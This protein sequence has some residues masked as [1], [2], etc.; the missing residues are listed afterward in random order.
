MT[1]N[2]DALSIIRQAIWAPQDERFLAAAID[3]LMGLMQL[4]PSISSALGLDRVEVKAV[5]EYLKSN[6]KSPQFMALSAS[7]YKAHD[8]KHG[9]VEHPLKGLLTACPTFSIAIT[10]KS[11]S[12]TDFSAYELL[13]SQ[14]LERCISRNLQVAHSDFLQSIASIELIESGVLSRDAGHYEPYSTRLQAV[15][16]GLRRLVKVPIHDDFQSAIE[17][18]SYDDWFRSTKPLDRQEVAGLK[19]IA[20]FILHPDRSRKATKGKR[21]GRRQKTHQ[22]QSVPGPG[23][24]LESSIIVQSEPIFDEQI[25]IREIPISRELQYKARVA[26][27]SPIELLDAKNGWDTG[28]ELHIYHSA[29]SARLAGGYQNQHKRNAAELLPWHLS[30]VPRQVQLLIINY[31]DEHKQSSAQSSV[32]A[33]LLLSIAS[34]RYLPQALHGL[35]VRRDASIPLEQYFDASTLIVFDQVEGAIALTVNAAPLVNKVV[36]ATARQTRSYVYVPDYFGI[37]HAFDEFFNDPSSRAYNLSRQSVSYHLNTSQRYLDDIKFRF[38]VSESQLWQMLPRMM[39][40]DAGMFSAMVLLT[41]WRTLNATVD[42]HYFAPQAEYVVSRY[43]SAMSRLLSDDHGKFVKLEAALPV[44]NHYVGAINCPSASDIKRLISG[45]SGLLKRPNL[46]SADR[47]NYLTLYTLLLCTA[48]FGL[49]HSL[50]PSFEISKYGS[51]S[52]MTYVEKGS[53]RCFVVPKLVADQIYVQ[54]ECARIRLLD[55]SIRR[56]NASPQGSFF[57]IDSHNL[58]TKIQPNK[59]SELLGTIKIKF[60]YPLNSLRRMMF[61][62]AFEYGVRGPITDF[63]GGHGVDGRK[64]FAPMS[65]LD[66]S[67][68]EDFAEDVDT[69]LREEGWSLLL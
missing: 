65:G 17:N 51:R 26:D 11:E 68:M 22:R 56:D 52:L 44:A 61:T 45:L 2:L 58:I 49:R 47:H 60:P 27:C 57:W 66:I 35:R 67:V 14:V 15:A 9:R 37:L 69:L 59:I 32:P 62:R 16:Y 36:V 29:E 40:Q 21:S 50:D 31:L 23:T 46:A 63:Y 1:Q 7:P 64:P 20:N 13:V 43:C 24:Y 39:Q 3:R 38:G 6:T 25:R 55:K 5:A 19:R 54:Q 30:N 33:A 42:L 4:R 48:G 8:R 41:G 18:Q 34:G 12:S 53:H 28:E 10:T